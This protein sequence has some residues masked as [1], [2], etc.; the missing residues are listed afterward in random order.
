M[1]TSEDIRDM[2]NEFKWVSEHIR[3]EEE[4]EGWICF[5]KNKFN[6]I[7]PDE[8]EWFNLNNLKE[9]LSLRRDM[10][11]WFGKPYEA[12]NLVP[13]SIHPQLVFRNDLRIVTFEEYMNYVN[14]WK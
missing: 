7:H 1:S 11:L 12:R 3:T 10:I 6:G 2:D 8:A 5:F 13:M 4:R 14:I 9:T